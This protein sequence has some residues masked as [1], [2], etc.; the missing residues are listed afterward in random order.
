MVIQRLKPL[1]L[2]FKQ[3][4]KG[5]KDY[6]KLT[7]AAQ[8]INDALKGQKV[9]KEIQEERVIKTH[10][11]K[12]YY[13]ELGLRHTQA[14]Y[15]DTTALEIQAQV[16]FWANLKLTLE[17]LSATTLGGILGTTNIGPLIVPIALLTPIIR[18]TRATIASV[19][20][21]DDVDEDHKHN[22]DKDYKDNKDEDYEDNKDGKE[23][24]D[25]VDAQIGWV[26]TGGR[27]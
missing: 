14:Q 22:K 15:F 21:T 2:V 25:N 10:E 26:A 24:S 19:A 16:K 17:R 1:Q 5:Q 20:I 13:T 7:K 18:T 9:T 3:T 8:Y 6:N 23:A 12:L 11:D 27:V 4:L